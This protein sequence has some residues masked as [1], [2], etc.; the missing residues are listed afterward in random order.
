M[1]VKRKAT[2]PLNHPTLEEQQDAL[3]AAVAC[4]TTQSVQRLCEQVGVQY[5]SHEFMPEGDP[6]C[7]FGQYEGCQARPFNVNPN[8]VVRARRRAPRSP[9]RP[10][11]ADGDQTSPPRRPTS[12]SLGLSMSSI[13][14]DD[15]GEF[16][17]ILQVTNTH[18]WGARVTTHS[19]VGAMHWLQRHAV[20]L[21]PKVIGWSADPASS[22][23]GCE[24]V[25]MSKA[26]GIELRKIWETLRPSQQVSYCQQLADWLREVGTV[27]RPQP[28]ELLH[29][30]VSGFRILPAQTKRTGSAEGRHSSRW[31]WPVGTDCPWASNSPPFPL[32]AGYAA[33]AKNTI[34][35]AV[36]RIEEEAAN[37]SW[38]SG[39]GALSRSSLLPELRKVLEFIDDYRAK[40]EGTAE[41]LART[42]TASFGVC[43]GDLH[44][45]NLLCDPASGRLTAVID[46]ESVSWGPREAD[47]LEFTRMMPEIDLAAPAG[48]TSEGVDDDELE[49]HERHKKAA[50]VEETKLEASEPAPQSPVATLEYAP[51]Q[52]LQDLMKHPPIPATAGHWERGLLVP[53]LLNV[54]FLHYFNASWWG[55]FVG[56]ERKRSIV[57]GEA[58]EAEDTLR[59]CLRT[60]FALVDAG[61]PR[62]LQSEQDPELSVDERDIILRAVKAIKNSASSFNQVSNQDGFNLNK[63]AITDRGAMALAKVLSG[64]RVRVLLLEG[65]AIT[66]AG[67]ACLAE[68][69]IGSSVR[70]IVLSANSIGDAG[71]AALVS[72]LPRTVVE[73]IDLC[74]GFSVAK[75]KITDSTK[76]RLRELQNIEGTP[77]R[78]D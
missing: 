72:A 62:T 18:Q 43:H 54:R 64:S 27:P 42:C 11:L 49:A 59:D 7:T 19:K 46:W 2:P 40:Y 58:K 78:F 76:A 1:A 44:L 15:D 74:A 28:A 38:P 35:D 56:M 4:V 33:H 30:A 71:A 65:N 67:A 41:Q 75:G 37:K 26:R 52:Q 34:E 10:H 48:Q 31:D 20:P 16:E 73:R 66:D 60:F 21:V 77:I 70:E 8:W 45:G 9:D 61:P 55:H 47:S 50:A 23:L 63:Q 5:S 12:A 6:G 32:C 36:A 57:P 17:M 24:Y 53:V 69:L 13:D 29:C 39:F 25:L 14:L 22:A 3:D 51:R 68:A